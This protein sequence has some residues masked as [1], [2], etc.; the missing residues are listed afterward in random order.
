MQS[1]IFIAFGCEGDS[2]SK[3]WVK[4]EAGQSSFSSAG[5]RNDAW[6]VDDH[7]VEGI[8]PA[9][10][11]DDRVVD[12]ILSR[13]VH[14]LDEFFTMDTITIG[15]DL[16]FSFRS[17]LDLAVGYRCS[18]SLMMYISVG[19]R[20]TVPLPLGRH[21]TPTSISTNELLPED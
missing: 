16:D 13:R 19:R 8:S 20:V 10:A 3:A 12:D 21:S 7:E 4:S 11:C 9:K 17:V 6:N 5:G 2:S 15:T 1:A 14:F 18:E